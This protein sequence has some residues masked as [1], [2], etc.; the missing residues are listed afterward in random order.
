MTF[1]LKFTAFDW[2]L[3]T[4][5]THQKIETTL[6][7]LLEALYPHSSP[8]HIRYMHYTSLYTQTWWTSWFPILCQDP[9]KFCR[10]FDDLAGYL[11]SEEGWKIAVE[12]LTKRKVSLS[13]PSVSHRQFALHFSVLGCMHECVWH[14]YGL[15]LAWC[16]WWYCS[17]TLGHSCSLEQFLDHWWDETVGKQLTTYLFIYASLHLFA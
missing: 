1:L 13:A 7:S 5:L 12:E 17:P 14:S 9:S 8:V 3:M 6:K 10:A 4:S 15:H 16:F 2:L 11:E